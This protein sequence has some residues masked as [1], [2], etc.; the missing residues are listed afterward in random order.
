MGMDP[1]MVLL[2][3]SFGLTDSGP[4]LVRFEPLAPACPLQ[5]RSG[6]GAVLERQGCFCQ[7][8]LLV[9]GEGIEICAVVPPP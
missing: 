7:T 1:E 9:T 3:G 8:W 4:W 6:L 2:E 5:I